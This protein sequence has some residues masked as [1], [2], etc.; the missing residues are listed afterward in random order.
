M[1]GLPIMPAIPP[2]ATAFQREAMAQGQP[3]P[4]Q[5]VVAT[6]PTQ[7]RV[8][9]QQAAAAP[10]PPALQP[11]TLPTPP[12]RRTRLVGPPPTFD[13]NVLQDMHETR[14][15]PP[16]PEVRDSSL[17]E[18]DTQAP[19]GPRDMGS[20]PISQGAQTSDYASYTAFRGLAGVEDM[21]DTTMDR[22]V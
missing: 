4:G 5:G 17:R 16:E 9:V 7:T 15:A 20:E 8:A 12:D 21:A 3:A 14:K 6:V 10:K 13:V 11:Q 19:N 22:S 18:G 2:A 1:S